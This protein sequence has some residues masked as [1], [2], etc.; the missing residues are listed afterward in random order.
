MQIGLNGVLNGISAGLERLSS[1]PHTVPLT[2]GEK[3]CKVTSLVQL[4]SL[5]SLAGCSPAHFG[6]GLV[7]AHVGPWPWVRPAMSSV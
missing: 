5:F 4:M 1:P 3:A 6:Q 7:R 2:K